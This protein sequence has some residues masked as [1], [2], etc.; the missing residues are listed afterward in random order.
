MTAMLEMANWLQTVE[1]AAFELYQ[2]AAG[3]FGA[4]APFVRFLDRLA[5]DETE[6]YHLMG[7][8]AQYLGSRPA[9]A[10]SDVALTD[11][12]R[13]RVEEPLRTAL[14][15]LAAGRMSKRKMVD[16][17]ATAEFSEWNTL[18]VYVVNRLK[19]QSR[20]F[21]YGAA[22]MQGHLTRIARFLDGLPEADRPAV[23]VQNLPRVW[24]EAL[25]I[26]EDQDAIRSLMAM[27]LSRYGKVETAASGEE[28]L[29]RMRRS[30][31]S[32][33]LTDI[34]L[35]G[36]DGLELFEA[37]LRLDPQIAPHFLFCSGG[38][39]LETWERMQRDNL[40]VLIKPFALDDLRRAVERIIGLLPTA[41]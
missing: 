10:I 8:A 15:D 9:P 31:Y 26:V 18:F 19:E 3:L 30:Y 37:A 11:E 2:Q 41:G 13:Q 34:N 17:L 12:T 24:E 14:A 29:A 33:I 32:V 20:E 27:F 21:Q 36:M 1:H 7:S 23:D 4:D 39:S 28:A 5:Q 38:L 40:A 6:H 22:R 35:P 16:H 25:L